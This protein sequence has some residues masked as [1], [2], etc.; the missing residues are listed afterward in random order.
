M[1]QCQI[2]LEYRN[3]ADD[4]PGPLQR[5]RLE[6]VY[7]LGTT[8]HRGDPLAGIHLDLV[9]IEVHREDT[10]SGAA[11]AIGKVTAESPQPVQNDVVVLGDMRFPLARVASLQDC[12]PAL[13][14]SRI[15]PASR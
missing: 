9:R 4:V 8:E 15:S 10:V 13:R 5:E 1:Q 3:G 11:Q 2:G 14:L 7:V 12:Q 6:Q